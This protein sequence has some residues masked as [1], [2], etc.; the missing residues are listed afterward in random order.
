M[1]DRKAAETVIE[2][3]LGLFRPKQ[4]LWSQ[5]L[6]ACEGLSHAEIARAVDDVIKRAIL[7]DKQVVFS[8]ELI[9]ALD[10]RRAAKRVLSGNPDA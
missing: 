3:H 9:A 7:A 4:V 6:P 1:P 10:E 5:V 8:D 2:R